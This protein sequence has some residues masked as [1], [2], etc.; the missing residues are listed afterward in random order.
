[1]AE[2]TVGWEDHLV[3]A[4]IQVGKR[5]LAEVE[6]ETSLRAGLVARL[7]T[8]GTLA[9]VLVIRGMCLAMVCF[10]M[11]REDS[12]TV[13]IGAIGVTTRTSTATMMAVATTDIMVTTM[14]VVSL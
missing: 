9:M 7:G 13:V 2:G 11:A 12:N 14:L 1:V 6:A 3:V 10:E 8:E 5:V 4:E